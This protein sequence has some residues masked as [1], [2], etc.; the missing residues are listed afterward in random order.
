MQFITAPAAAAGGSGADD[1]APRFEY[2]KELRFHG[3]RIEMGEAPW[4]A[5]ERPL[6]CASLVQALPLPPLPVALRTIMH[7]DVNQDCTVKI[8]AKFPSPPAQAAAGS[9]LLSSHFE[10]NCIELYWIVLYCAGLAAPLHDAPVTVDVDCFIKNMRALLAPPH[11]T[12]LASLSQAFLSASSNLYAF[13]PPF[14][15]LLS[16]RSFIHSLCMM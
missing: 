11:L 3:F 1:M 5:E 6:L 12:L 10:S 9:L 15:P 8:H 7:G 13:I 14:T 2:Q 16:F 4:Y